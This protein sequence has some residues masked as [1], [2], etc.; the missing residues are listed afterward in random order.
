MKIYSSD[1]R[2]FAGVVGALTIVKAAQAA[3][4]IVVAGVIDSNIRWSWGKDSFGTGTYGW[5]AHETTSDVQSRGHPQTVPG[6][7]CGIQSPPC[8]S[9]ML[10]R[11]VHRHR[12]EL[13]VEIDGR[14]LLKDQ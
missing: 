7:P 9:L 10:S 14:V 3:G 1:W 5:L 2:R 6:P 11:M 4:S 8:D 13:N 12:D